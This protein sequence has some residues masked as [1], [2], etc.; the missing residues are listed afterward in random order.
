MMS[1]RLLDS[2]FVIDCLLADPGALAELDRMF[3][4]GDQPMVN[5]VVVCEV[6]AGLNEGD[7]R[8]FDALLEPTEFVQP[9]PDAALKAGEWRVEARRRGYAL[10]LA[11][12]LIGAAAE[13]SDAPV[14]T[15][16]VRDFALMPIR[17][18]SY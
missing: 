3:A 15:R 8:H 17:V 14:L 18:E 11:D 2:T 7:V 16:N 12:A 9:G 1:Y 4:D 6:R 5:E 13:A 10:S